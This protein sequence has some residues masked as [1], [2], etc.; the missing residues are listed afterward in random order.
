[1]STAHL[2]GVFTSLHPTMSRGG[3]NLFRSHIP[4]LRELVVL[5]DL[6]PVLVDALPSRQ[7]RRDRDGDKGEDD[8]RDEDAEFSADLVLRVEDDLRV[9]SWPSGGARQLTVRTTRP[10]L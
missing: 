5:P 10:T 8:P 3:S 1:M 2:S 9:S 4:L 7:P 6:A